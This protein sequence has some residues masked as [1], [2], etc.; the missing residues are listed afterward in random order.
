MKKH[1]CLVLAVVVSA[2]ASNA[3]DYPGFNV[4]W[5]D[6]FTGNAGT[7]PNTQVWNLING[8]LNVNGELETYS[9]S[10]KNVQLSGGSTLQIVP[11]RNST[12]NGGWTSGR[13]E[14]SY[15]FTPSAGVTMAEAKIRFGSTPIANK[16]GIWPAFWTLGDAIR[17]G[18]GWPGC[19][20]LDILETVNG[21]LTGYGTMHCD[22][23][24]GG[25]CNEPQGIG[26]HIS[27]PD[28]SWHTWRITWDLT[29]C[30][31]TQQTI[32]W[33]LDGQQYFQIN[34]ARINNLNVWNS[35]TAKPLYFI[36]NVAVGGGWPGYPDGTTLDGFG[37]MMEVAYVA[38]YEN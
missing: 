23:Y 26:G 20:E 13:M 35:V 14:S 28:Q 24:P 2:F 27:F 7:S 29:S 30:D 33:S 10:T 8:H 37:S 11:W 15:T 3:P 38:L 21:Q 1:I 18:T 36:L 22:V 9:S 34:G 32:S 25:I 31:W 12:V 16:K 4:I 6:P 17:H 5:Q 19:G